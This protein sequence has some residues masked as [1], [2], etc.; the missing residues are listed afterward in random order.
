MEKMKNYRFPVF[1]LLSI[2]IG[3]MVGLVME[4]DAVILQPIGDVFLNL[5]FTIIVPLFSLRF[6]PLLQ[7]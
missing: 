1:L 5:L 2:L 3:A 6:P 7:I 4:E